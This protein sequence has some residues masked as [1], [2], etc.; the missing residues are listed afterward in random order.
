MQI[1]TIC[2][3]NKTTAKDFDPKLK[4]DIYN[5]SEKGWYSMEIWA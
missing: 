1:Q 4:G 3:D 5:D 2:T